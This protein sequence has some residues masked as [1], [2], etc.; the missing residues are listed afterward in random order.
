MTSHPPI[1]GLTLNYRDVSRTI[2]CVRS[3]LDEGAA[4]VLIWD[5]S[6]DGGASADALSESL[7]Q[8]SRVGIER[9][10]AN[11]GFAAG[12]NRG[13][14]WIA[15]RFGTSWVLLINNDARLLPGA[16]EALAGTLTRKNQAV[17]AYP[18]IDH[19]GD[20][21]GTVYY[22]RHTGLLTQR[23]LPGSFPYASGCCLLIAPERINQ[24]LFDEDL[25]M[26]GEDWV[27]GWKLGAQGMAHVPKTLVFHEGS[28]SSGLGSE[29]YET[30]MVAAHWTL[31]R[32]LART[33]RD[34][35]LMMTARLFTLTARA[36]LRAFRYRSIV[37]LRALREGWRIARGRS[38]VTKPEAFEY[39]ATGGWSRGSLEF[40]SKCPVCDNQKRP[41][42]IYK[43]RDDE[44]SSAD[45][46]TMWRCSNCGSL[47]LNPRPNAVSLPKAY[48]QYYTHDIE[49]DEI[50]GN[51]L[52][53][54]VQGFI[55]GYLHQR[56]G[57]SRHPN[58]KSGAVIFSLIE[59][60][61]LKLNYYCRHLPKLHKN[62]HKL[63]LDIG[64][65]NGAFLKRASE[66]C[67]A[68]LGCEPDKKAVSAC[69]AQGLKVI[70]G[71]AFHPALDS[72]QFD[73]ITM[74]HVLEHVADPEQLL[75]RAN[76]LLSPGGL[77]W[78]ALPNP[79]SIGLRA[80]KA[81]WRGLH[82]PFHLI[83]PSQSALKKWLQKTD[84]IGIKFLRRGA[85]SSSLWR[86]SAEIST[87]EGSAA[88][89]SWLVPV[90]KELSD[91]LATLTPLWGEE[92]III[93]RK[94][95]P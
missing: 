9:S 7:N 47:Y 20:V 27:S 33:P 67:W 87:R 22:Q 26:Y 83:I 59:P 45:L 30:H 1:I 55:N 75:N 69:Q 36:F 15:R 70:H 14:E 89:T 50:S 86:L 77:L 5:N 38:L 23:P 62:E 18:N 31:A 72:Q 28:T 12:V 53:R 41:S 88:I 35:A 48:F 34:R 43:R 46:W 60:L 57:I 74:S 76:Q 65:G 10:P 3:L 73:V 63:L 90:A 71:N 54:S 39:P 95:M 79:N 42:G 82:P 61:R 85:Q 84:Y 94:K 58:Y 16:I 40:L 92:T 8:D 6:E 19:S 32:K 52:S 17:I 68:T 93:A 37:P 44:N 29:F 51:L 25:F 2:T 80:F 56:F 66:M 11:L 4:H 64:C 91:L 21:I 49:A 13:M 81:G 24:P 78:I